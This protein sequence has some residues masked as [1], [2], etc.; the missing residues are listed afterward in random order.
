MFEKLTTKVSMITPLLLKVEEILVCTR[1]RR[2]PRL[3]SY[4]RHWELKLFDAIGMNQRE[5]DFSHNF[6]KNII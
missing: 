3:A 1:T 5:N 6:C 2:S 4:Y